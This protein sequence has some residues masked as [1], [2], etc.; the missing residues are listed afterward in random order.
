MLKP[1]SRNESEY[2]R[3]PRVFHQ[4]FHFGLATGT[5]LPRNARLLGV[6]GGFGADLFKL[7][8]HKLP[9]GFRRGQSVAHDALA[10]LPDAAGRQARRS[11]Q[12]DRRNGQ[13][14]PGGRRHD[15]RRSRRQ[16]HAPEQQRSYPESSRHDF[17]S[18]SSSA[19][20]RFLMRK[21][22]DLPRAPKA[23]RPEVPMLDATASAHKYRLDASRA[24]AA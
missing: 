23:P 4:L 18:F 10:G 3:K 21:T 22:S 20:A 16:R 12:R 2:K 15:K 6:G 5:L 11:N 17:H 8:F 7:A 13:S 14:V 19:A 9:L 24:K 1:V